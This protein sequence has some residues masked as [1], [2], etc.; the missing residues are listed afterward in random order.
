MGMGVFALD[1]HTFDQVIDSVNSASGQLSRGKLGV[2]FINVNV[3]GESA[4]DTIYQVY[5][6]ILEQA[7]SRRIWGGGRNRRIGAIVLK[8]AP[9]RTEAPA[10]PCTYFTCKTTW[11]RVMQPGLESSS[12]CSPSHL[13]NDLVLASRRTRGDDMNAGGRAEGT[14]A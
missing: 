2:V 6:R 12:E 9:S 11:L 14:G 5:L 1:G 10:G 3:A 8:L 7:L 4:S 13:I